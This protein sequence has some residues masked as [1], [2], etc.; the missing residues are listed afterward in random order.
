MPKTTPEFFQIRYALEVGWS[1]KQAVCLLLGINPNATDLSTRQIHAI[2]HLKPKLWAAV[3]NNEISHAREFRFGQP[4][5]LSPE[6]ILKWAKNQEKFKIDPYLETARK[7]AI[8]QALGEKK[9]GQFDKLFYITAAKILW[10]MHDNLSKERTPDELILLVKNLN[11]EYGL[12]IALKEKSSIE[13]YLA[14]VPRNRPAGR[15][16]N[17]D[18]FAGGTNTALFLDVLKSK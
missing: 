5:L 14:D 12:E 15:P 4:I 9:T 16:K 1:L 13:E 3:K 18:R 2:N 10:D 7:W 6:D 17:A 11:S 8:G